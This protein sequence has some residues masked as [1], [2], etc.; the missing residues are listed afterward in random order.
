MIIR[1]L[2]I[3]LIIATHSKVVG[4]QPEVF[5]GFVGLEDFK[6]SFTDDS[7]AEALIL[8][9]KS[10]I[11]FT[12]DSKVGYQIENQVLIR[13]KI[14]KPSALEEA[15]ISIPIFKKKS[16]YS[17]SVKNI[18][19][20]TCNLENGEIIR[21]E[22]TDQDIFNEKISQNYSLVKINF[23]NVKVGSIIEY[24]Y[25]FVSPM[26]LD[27][28]PTPWYF[29]GS[30]PKLWSEIEFT[31]PYYFHYRTIQ[32]GDLA[33]IID[34]KE[35]TKMSIVTSDLE[36]CTK[37]NIALKDIPAFKAEPFI[38]SS[39]DYISKIEFELTM[40]TFRG[41][42]PF[43]YSSN[44]ESVNKYFYDNI[45][46]LDGFKRTKYLNE[47]ANNFSQLPKTR[48]SL[49]KIYY[50]FKDLF[51]TSSDNYRLDV[52]DL[53]QVFENKR[54]TS[55]EL[56]LL[57]VALLRK[58]NYQA[59]PV[60]ISTRSNG[61][62]DLEY[63]QIS[64]FN[65]IACKVNL[66]STSLYVDIS[67]E[68]L[69]LGMLP[70]ECLNTHG[71]EINENNG[72]FVSIVPSEKFKVYDSVEAKIDIDAGKIKG[73]INQSNSGYK[74]VEV[75]KRR[76]DKGETK[77]IEELKQVHNSIRINNIQLTSMIDPEK[78]QELKFE[79]ES[80]DNFTVE[81]ILYINPF[82]IKEVKDNPFKTSDRKHPVNFGYS[83]D[84]TYKLSLDISKNLEVISLPT[85]INM[86]LSNLKGQFIY[87][88]SFDSTNNKINL[89]SKIVLRNPIYHAEQYQELKEL[90]NRI[91]QKQEEQIVLKRK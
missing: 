3:I 85:D 68:N 74:A 14:L 60:F 38:A 59:N 1:V 45:I 61:I 58:L 13:K 35:E 19:G 62:F 70:Y 24:L 20:N 71:F 56:N 69:K 40:T 75:R 64:K 30:I 91:I 73:N 15:N 11:K 25:V 6:K 34:T 82:F 79:F 66:D 84:F 26:N 48:E 32:K 81:D 42:F 27:N 8:Y 4:Q 23:P 29:Q 7:S 89:I 22:I 31:I 46:Q 49:E 41:Q 12:Y 43:F 18:M 88:C 72:Q 21:N 5:L 57:M 39:D 10:S 65:Y 44:W 16:F 67:D 52:D 51:K 76:K 53:K 78:L 37:Y 9:E 87:S 17:Q 86:A 36:D 33:S 90:Y 2:I 77:F 47:I 83:K 54:G 50:N 55:S 80:K 28:K 63:P